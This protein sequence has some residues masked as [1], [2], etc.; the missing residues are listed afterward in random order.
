MPRL[1]GPI[2]INRE[3]R[4]FSTSRAAAA[5]AQWAVS[6][7]PVHSYSFERLGG[8]DAKSAYYVGIVMLRSDQAWLEPHLQERGVRTQVQ[9]PKKED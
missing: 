3:P 8:S 6:G 1:K 2:A 7:I 4:T 5:H 9:Q